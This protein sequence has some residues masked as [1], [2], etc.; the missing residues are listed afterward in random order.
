LRGSVE[1]GFWMGEKRRMK[2]IELV[3]ECVGC[4]MRPRVIRWGVRCEKVGSGCAG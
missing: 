3:N 2:V 1:S 4:G